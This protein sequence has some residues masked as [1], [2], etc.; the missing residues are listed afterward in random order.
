MKTL[1]SKI[2]AIFI[3]VIIISALIFGVLI[4]IKISNTGDAYAYIT[5]DGIK[6]DFLIHLPQSYSESEALPLIIALHGGGGNAKDMEKLTENGFN[7]LAAKGNFIVV[8]PNGIGRHWNDGR[9]LSFY[10]TQ[11]ENINDVKFISELIDYMVE[12]YNVNPLRVYVTGMSN[13]ALMTYRLAYELSN[14]IAAVAPVDGSIPLNIYLNETPIAPIP[15]LMINNVADPILPWNGGYAHF[16]NKKLGKVLSVE[17]TAAFWA[18]IDNCT[19]VKSKEYLPDTDPNDGT[20]VWMRLYLNNT[21]GMEVIQYGIDG[22]G[23]TWPSGEQYLPQSIIGKTSKD[24][25]A[26]NLIWEFFR[27]YQIQSE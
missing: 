10:Y 8:Y 23:H 6:R 2:V 3:T 20:R 11:K 25:N 27:N 14:K 26:C 4:Y 13:G 1:K 18:R 22:G 16:G 7:K 24:I 12:K 5:V 15:V 19:L 21:T 17:E 9:N